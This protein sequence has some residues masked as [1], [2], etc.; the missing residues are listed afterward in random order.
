WK[1]CPR[2]VDGGT[3]AL[4][5][6]EQARKSN[7]PFSLMILDVHMPEM[8]GFALAEKILQQGGIPGMR[9]ILLTSTGQ[10][11]DASRCREL[12]ISA[13]LPKPI[14]QSELLQAV[15]TV[16][17]E[18]RT[19]GSLRNV[20]TR[21]SLRETNGSLHILLVEDNHVNQKLAVRLLEKQ[22]H[23]VTVAENGRE[24]L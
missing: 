21:H 17:G 9:M 12:G 14:K 1:M 6:L 5:A 13:Y 2:S 3:S 10:Q 23:T 20:V 16:L 24:A 18:S 11:G 19:G 8:D 4:I 15:L 7:Q 22:G